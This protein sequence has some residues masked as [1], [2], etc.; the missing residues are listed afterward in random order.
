MAADCED[1]TAKTSPIDYQFPHSGAL[2]LEDADAIGD[3]VGARIK[4]WRLRQP[5]REREAGQ[6]RLRELAALEAPEG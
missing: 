3:I 4:D 2:T 6:N 1:R 5:E